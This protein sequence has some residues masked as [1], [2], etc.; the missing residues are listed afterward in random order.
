[1]NIIYHIKYKNMINHYNNLKIMNI[2][3]EE[4]KN[5][6]DE[7][8]KK[9]EESTK[10]PTKEKNGNPIIPAEITSNFCRKPWIRL[11]YPIREVKLIE[12]V[13]EKEFNKIEKDRLLKLLYEKKLTSK[14][15]TYNIE[16]GKI[17]DIALD[18]NL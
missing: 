13:K 2:E 15:V 4:L 6:I 18:S 10:Q 16:I 14:V 1:M 11:P 5:S 17:E 8:K 9:I 12:Y 7:M 3:N